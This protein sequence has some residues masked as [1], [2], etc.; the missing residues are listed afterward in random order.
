MGQVEYRPDKCPPR[1]IGQ[2]NRGDQGVSEEGERREPDVQKGSAALE[3]TRG[4]GHDM[5]HD[6]DPT[7]DTLVRRYA[8]YVEATSPKSILLNSQCIT[9]ECCRNMEEGCDDDTTMRRIDVRA[10]S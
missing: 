8:L 7:D 2:N 6:D 4:N 3:F 1:I 9:R 5:V 10:F